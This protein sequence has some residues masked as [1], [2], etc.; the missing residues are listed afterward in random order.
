[1]KH[2]KLFA[3][4]AVAAFCIS[5]FAIAIDTEDSSADGEKLT[6]SFYLELKD[7][8]SSYKAR[9]ADVEVDGATPTG[10][11]YEAALT[12]ACAA[13]SGVTLTMG[14]YNMITSIEADG[15]VYAGS[16]Y[17]DWGTDNYKAFAVYYVDGK[18]WKSSSLNDKTMLAIVFDKYAF[19]EPSDASKYWKN[20]YEGMDPYWSA[21]PTVELVNYKVYFQLKDSDGSSYS[22]WIESIQMGVSGESLK[23][24]RALGSKEA[25]F[26]VENNAKYATSLKSITADGHKY[27]TNGT[28]GE[29]SYFGFCAY[30]KAEGNEWKDLQAA[31]LDSATI[32][33]HV[34][35]NYKFADP[36][37]S[38]YYFH[39]AAYGMDAYWTKLPSVSP[40]DDGNNNTILYIAIGAVAVV[41]VVVVAFFLLKKKA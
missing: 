23:S 16:A 11:L 32:V 31:D 30:C 39:E 8:T 36:Q 28:Y 4:I 5:A 33:A 27:A 15:H 7:G 14:A 25:G 37:D 19:S 20:E 6:Y 12:A 40:T 1:M 29:S 13:T 21:L 2:A 24:A 38:S 3:I 10:D 41:A 18:E 9:L 17:S 22:K 35:D 34:F 26:T